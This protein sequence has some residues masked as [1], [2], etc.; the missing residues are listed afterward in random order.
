MRGDFM[1]K[2]ENRTRSIIK[3][4]LASNGVTLTDVVKIMNERHP[5]EPTTQQNLTNKLAR[6]T[7]KFTEVEEIAD[8]L[9][10]DIVFQ[11]RSSNE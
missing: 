3:S 7:I 9:E 8:I 10:H 4:F 1:K 11:K 2:D 5:N 6:E